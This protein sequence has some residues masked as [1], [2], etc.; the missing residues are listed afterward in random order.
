M[1]ETEQTERAEIARL[2]AEVVR[3]TVEANGYKAEVEESD[4]LRER[5][6]G[7]LTRTV[8]VLRGEPPENTQWSWHD[9]PERTEELK[10]TVAL[11]GG[12]L[13]PD[14]S[15]VVN[16]SKHNAAF[17]CEKH[18][19]D[20]YRQQD[21]NH[22]ML[23]V[24][25][26]RDN[27]MTERN[28]E[29]QGLFHE[30]ENE[31]SVVIKLNE[32]FACGHRK[33]DWD[34]SYG[35]CVFCKIKQQADDYDRL[36]HEVF[37][38]HDRIDE[39]EAVLADASK[40]LLSESDLIEYYKTQMAEH[41]NAAIASRKRAEELEVTIREQGDMIVSTARERDDARTRLENQMR[42]ARARGAK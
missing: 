12:E 26:E 3:M 39:L 5:L 22:C 37:E 13:M 1:G 19:A 40:P 8:N 35:E 38:C 2:E 29:W 14:G 23:C 36:P 18:Q 33:V 10:A 6:A 25:E 34:D 41:R 32:R 20:N 17:R 30:W 27:L 7:L 4:A 28:G 11:M 15:L 21:L 24:L 16:M 42:A 9:I 31:R